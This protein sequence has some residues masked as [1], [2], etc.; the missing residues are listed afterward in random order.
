[1]RIWLKK[2]NY[3]EYTLS[4]VQEQSTEEGSYDTIPVEPD[5]FPSPEKIQK[6]LNSMI[7]RLFK[8]DR[9]MR[10]KTK[11]ESFSQLQF[12]EKLQPYANDIQL[13]FAGS[14]S[15]VEAPDLLKNL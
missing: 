1:M 8:D 14:N 15:I 2:K 6:V 10:Q 3:Y 9:L 5:C 7:A 11:I 12:C 4:Y 13:W